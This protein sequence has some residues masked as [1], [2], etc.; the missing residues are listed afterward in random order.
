MYQN[1]KVIGLWMDHEGAYVINTPDNTNVGD[2]E[3]ITKIKSNLHGSFGSSQDANSNK[4]STELHQ[5]F[6][7]LSREL[8]GNDFAYVIGPGKAQEEFRNFVKKEGALK[9]LKMEVD[10]AEAHMTNNQMVAKVRTHFRS[11]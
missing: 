1:K 10:T 9:D 6:K 3:V 5:Y 8:N 2:F 7:Q 11:E 4:I